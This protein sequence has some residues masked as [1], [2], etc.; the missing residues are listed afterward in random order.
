M[1]GAELNTFI[2]KH[3]LSVGCVVVA[4][5]CGGLL[6]YRSSDI[7]TSQQNFE[8]KRAEAGKVTSNVRNA[9]GLPEQV[10]DIEDQRKELETRLIKVS[11]LAVNLQ[12]FYKLEAETSV[13]LSDVRQ[14]AV[15]R[16]NPG[17][18]RYVAVPFSVSVQGTFAQLVTF[19]N[20]LQNG[21]HF[22]RINSASF[23][24]SGGTGDDGS[25]SMTLSLNLDL[26]GQQ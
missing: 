23:S 18:A 6:Y 19:L 11:Q 13:K 5:V 21:R 16:T 10:K 17:N 15:P 12:Y 14:N 7:A 2:K 20:G 9:A 22:C 4:L 25:S 3:P 8:A 24:K 1:T 26:L